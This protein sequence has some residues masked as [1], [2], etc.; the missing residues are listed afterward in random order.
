VI[1]KAVISVRLP[2]TVEKQLNAI[3]KKSGKTRTEIVLHSIEEFL[4]RRENNQTA[5]ELGEDLFESLP[6]GPIDLADA[7]IMAYA[8]RKEI[9]QILS[10]DSDFAIYRKLDGRTLRNMMH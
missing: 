1:Q 6:S 10:I 7:S 2:S 3:A 9:Q 4:A 5:Y 8:E